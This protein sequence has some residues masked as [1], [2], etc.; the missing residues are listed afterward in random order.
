MNPSTPQDEAASFLLPGAGVLSPISLA[1][2]ITYRRNRAL[3]TADIM[4]PYYWTASDGF[5]TG[6][7]DTKKLAA[8]DYRRITAWRR[9]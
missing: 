6:Y 7:G 2:G 5:A 1:S 4:A 8:K 9:K 3:A